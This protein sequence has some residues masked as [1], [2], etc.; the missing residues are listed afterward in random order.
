MPTYLDVEFESSDGLRLYARD[1]APPAP[2]AT[3]LCLPG[4]TA[5]S[6]DFENVAERLASQYRV[7]APDLRGRGRSGFDPEAEGFLQTLDMQDMLRLWDL[8]ALDRVVVLGTSLSGHT[9]MGLAAMVSG[10]PLGPAADAARAKLSNVAP[11]SLLGFIL[12]DIGPELGP[13][14]FPDLDALRRSVAPVSSWEE[15]I[16]QL[17][18]FAEHL[19]DYDD[20][21]WERVAR[22]RYRENDDGT[23]VL[24]YHPAV[25]PKPPPPTGA[26]EAPP[27]LPDLWPLFGMLGDVAALVVRGEHSGTLTAECV[28]EMQ[29]RHPG[30]D[31]ATIP[32][33]GHCPDLSEPESTAALDRFLDRV[34]G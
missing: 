13:D 26:G 3:L 31:A 16:E 1:Y 17:R 20:T 25:L 2:R 22:A 30:L 14:T 29:R 4:T 11:T 9:A 27:Q 33:R 7:I 28:S 23:P 19:D 10:K 12:N 8:L 32:R 6:A 21:D 24:A 34:C 18:A 15:A 5:N